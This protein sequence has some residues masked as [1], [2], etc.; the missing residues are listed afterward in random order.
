ME[1]TVPL[2]VDTAK[3]SGCGI[4]YS[5]CPFGA[6]TQGNGEKVN[7]DYEKCQLCGICYT[8]CPSSSI[9]LEYYDHN[10]LVKELERK[11]E[12]SGAENLVMMCRGASPVSCDLIDLLKV[13][14]SSKF[15]SLR[16]PCVGRIKTEFYLKA[17]SMGIKKIITIQCS[18]E[19]CHYRSGSH[20][21][22]VRTQELRELLNQFGYGDVLE[23]IENP[24]QVKYDP[25]NCVGCDKCV[26]V[27][28]YGAIEAQPLATPKINTEKCNGCGL[29]TIICPHLGLQIEDFEPQNI[30]LTISRYADEVNKIKKRGESAVLVFCCQWAEFSALDMVRDGFLRE[31]VAV[32]EIPCYSSLNPSHVLQAFNLG[33]DGV[34]AFVCSDED[35]KSRESRGQIEEG[36]NVLR[37]AL[38]RMNL[39][40]RFII[41]KSH[42]RYPGSFEEKLNSFLKVVDAL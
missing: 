11:M 24:H 19:F 6:I 38:R 12:D 18:D 9:E 40:N 3:C 14:D 7:I 27:C 29:C 15:V 4:C 41:Q 42:P 33:F 16:I 5:I 34:M 8:G 32:I 35:C 17:L 37:L 25:E 10:Y 26:F 36:M 13:E 28:P 31:N 30:E 1:M 2:K 23:I 20:F 39:E 21:N 22:K